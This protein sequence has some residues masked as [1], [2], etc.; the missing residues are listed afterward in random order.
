MIVLGGLGL[1]AAAGKPLTEISKKMTCV[2]EIIKNSQ[3]AIFLLIAL[4]AKAGQGQAD[5]DSTETFPEKVQYRVTAEKLAT[6]PGKVVYAPFFVTFYATSQ[7]AEAVWEKRALD[8]LKG[9]LTTADGRAAT[10]VRY[11]S[12]GYMENDLF[13]PHK[14]KPMYPVPAFE[15]LTRRDA[16]WG[17]QIVTSFSEA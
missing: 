14:W 3:F 2:Q 5:P 7:L 15:N 6:L 12:L 13:K 9:W 10:R 4:M 8:R 1:L 16:F 17:A 11:P